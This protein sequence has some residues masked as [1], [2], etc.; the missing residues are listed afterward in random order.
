MGLGDMLSKVFKKENEKE[1]K[2]VVEV[3]KVEESLTKSESTLAGEKNND[4]AQMA[5]SERTDEVL[6][7]NAEVKQEVN[8]E[9]SSHAAEPVTKEKILE[10]LSDVYDP[11][12]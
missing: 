10:V 7:E 5:K 8:S 12:I 6:I 3:Q 11:E 4:S 2:S 1:I 9:G